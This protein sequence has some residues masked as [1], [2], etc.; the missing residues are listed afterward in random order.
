MNVGEL[1]ERPQRGRSSNWT[2]KL[3]WTK[4]FDEFPV[5]T[6]HICRPRSLGIAAASRA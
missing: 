5:E 1:L 3:V 4:Q 2:I 6:A